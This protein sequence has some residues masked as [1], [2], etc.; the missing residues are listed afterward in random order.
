MPEKDRGLRGRAALPLGSFREDE[1]SQR[2]GGCRLVIGRNALRK[3]F[4]K[5]DTIS[6]SVMLLYI[7]SS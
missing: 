5:R 7:P 1:M 2:S 3:R 4:E 6:W